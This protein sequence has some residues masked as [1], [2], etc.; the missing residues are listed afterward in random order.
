MVLVRY[1]AAHD[2]RNEWVYNA[3]DIDA[4]AI[5]WAHDMNAGQNKELVDYYKDR[6]AWLVEPD[7]TPPRVSRYAITPGGSQAAGSSGQAAGS[8]VNIH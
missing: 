4:S 5:I 7:Q 1:E 3:A 6:Q 2:P 8:S